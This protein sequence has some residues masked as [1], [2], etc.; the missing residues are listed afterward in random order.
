LDSTLKHRFLLG[1]VILVSLVLAIAVV[2][3]TSPLV[4]MAI[5]GFA[6]L[7]GLFDLLEVVHQVAR[8]QTGLVAIA[9]VLLAAHT[10]AGLIALRLM[11]NRNPVMPLTA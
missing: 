4:P 10:A 11:A 9:L 3:T 5:V 7:F 6:V 1:G 8:G 2:I